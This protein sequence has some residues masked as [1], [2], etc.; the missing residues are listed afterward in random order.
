MPSGPADLCAPA[1]FSAECTSVVE[2]ST[3][4]L[5]CLTHW[6]RRAKKWL[7]LSGSKALLVGRDYIV[8]MWSLIVQMPF[9]MCL[10]AVISL[11]DELELVHGVLAISGGS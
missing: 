11:L 5:W 8:G 3:F 1:L 6:S 2:E 4:V 10:A 9:H 7:S